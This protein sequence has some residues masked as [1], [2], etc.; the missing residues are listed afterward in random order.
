MMRA[1]LIFIPSPGVGHLVPMV[2]L[3]KLLA[4]RDEQISISI[5][6]MNLPFESDKAALTQ[7]LKKDAPEHITFVDIPDVDETTRTELI[8]LPRMSFFNSFVENQRTQVR[9]IVVTIL[10]NS[11]SGKLGGFVIDMLCTSMID[12][13]NEFN[14]PAYVFFTSGAAFLSLMFYVQNLKDNES[15]EVHEY[16]DSDVKLSPP[17]FINPVPVKVLPSM[18]LSKDGFPGVIAMA[19]RLRKAKAI[20]VNTVLELEAHAIKSL[21]NDGNTPLIYHIGPIIHSMS[22]GAVINSNK[23]EEDIICWLNRQPLLSVV[24][25]CFGSIG[26]FDTAQV[27][28]IAQALE[29]SGHRFLWSLRRPSQEMERTELL[30]DYED[31]NEVLSE[32]FLKRTSGIGKVI[33]WAPQMTILSHPSVGG[34]V[35]HCGWNSTL[36]SAWCGVP[37]ATWPM[38]AEQQTNAFQ[39]VKELGIAAEIKM[40]YRK[41]NSVSSEPSILVTAKE[42]ERGISCLMD[43]ESEMR[44]KMKEMKNICR[45]AIVEGG[46]SN[47]SLGKFIEAVMDNF[48]EGSL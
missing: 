23:S 26:S 33:G 38:Y 25:L 47:T 46:S 9:D 39:L 48:Q 7:K 34:F 42:I 17:G 45:K 2:E 29:L 8:S 14:V 32:G 15:Q 11:K 44:T 30:T 27:T 43:G 4:S 28:E 37:M 5:L 31:Y 20:L 35:S 13:A 40:D 24:Y 16:K 22:G 6:I 21:A 19:R 1:E 3:A 41:D 12:V 36:E 10:K 18:M